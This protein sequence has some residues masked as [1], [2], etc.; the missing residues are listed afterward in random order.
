[1]ILVPNAET[2]QAHDIF[3]AHG[4]VDLRLT[5]AEP[6]M[7]KKREKKNTEVPISYRALEAMSTTT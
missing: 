6:G 7:S 3:V 1:M 2:Q 5:S 4:E